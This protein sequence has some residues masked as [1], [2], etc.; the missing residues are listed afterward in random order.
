MIF[1]PCAPIKHE[2]GISLDV[3]KKIFLVCVYQNF[4]L[5]FQLQIIAVT[6]PHSVNNFGIF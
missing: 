4:G 5:L 3:L 6:V 1:F 2:L